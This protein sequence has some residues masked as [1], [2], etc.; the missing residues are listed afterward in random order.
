MASIPYSLRPL[1]GD[2][3]ATVGPDQLAKLIG[4]PETDQADWKLRL[5]D[6]KKTN[7]D[8]A[9]DV[10]AFANAGGG[11]I[12]VGLAED[13]GDTNEAASF[14]GVESPGGLVDRIDSVVRARVQPPVA[15]TAC[16]VTGPDGTD[17]VL[18]AVE[19]SEAAPHAALDGTALRYPVRSGAGKGYLS[20][21]EIA[22][23]YGRRLRRIAGQDARTAELRAAA[24]P[25]ELL[26]DDIAWLAV[27]L[28]P[29]RPGNSR[30]RPND[31]E[32]YRDLLSVNKLRTFVFDQPSP[33]NP[34][35]GHRSLIAADYFDTPQQ[36]AVLAVDGSGSAALRWHGRS[37]GTVGHILPHLT[38]ELFWL[39]STLV[40][41][42][43][44]R[45][46]AGT[47][48]VTVEVL[49][50]PSITL[51]LGTGAQGTM[52]MFREE[53]SHTGS[54]PVSFH[55][56]DIDA[57]VAS[58]PELLAVV[59]LL[60]VDVAST[61]G[62]ADLPAVTAAGTI[63]ANRLGAGAG[64]LPVIEHWA[65]NHGVTIEP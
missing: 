40:A 54:T 26:D 44:E 32:R 3:P 22:D 11:L 17:V 8:L 13:D 19:P 35:V 55:T 12:V 24:V 20:E 52:S 21:A 23:W 28:A 56:L 42:A 65:Q 50:R 30:I 10:A 63:R 64:H 51:K 5:D 29:A 59:H 53:I 36:R 2:D 9:V 14:V 45:G 60:G 41:H 46:A 33:W 18:I 4:L 57:V 43:A 15:Y 48:T 16:H 58:T 38:N 31:V 62:H 37:D 7:A 61:F 47:A 39:L 1:L 49:A 34:Q 27:T 25:A 6:N